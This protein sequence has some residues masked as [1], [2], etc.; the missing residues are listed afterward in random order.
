MYTEISDELNK[1]LHDI[2]GLSIEHITANLHNQGDKKDQDKC[3]WF[4]G[5]YYC[6]ID[7]RWKL[8]K[9]I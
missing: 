8:I 9:C 5:C 3:T 6:F 4:Q 7:G 2:T 1:L